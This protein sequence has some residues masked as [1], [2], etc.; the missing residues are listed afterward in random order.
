MKTRHLH[1]GWVVIFL[2][3][4]QGC[5]GLNPFAKKGPS[6]ELKALQGLA[7]GIDQSSKSTKAAIEALKHNSM[8]VPGVLNNTPKDG[9]GVMTASRIAARE[10]N[11]S[12]SVIKDKDGNPILDKNGLPI[13]IYDEFEQLVMTGYKTELAGEGAGASSIEY[14]VGGRSVDNDR[15]ALTG[16]ATWDGM[17][18]YVKDLKGSIT[19]NS[20][21]LAAEIKAE[22][23]GRAKILEALPGVIRETF[24]GTNKR[25]ELL[26]DGRVRLITALGDSVIGRLISLTPTGAATEG[27][28]AVKAIIDSGNG[29][30]EFVISETDQ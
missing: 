2:I 3:V 27:A 30:E 24:I 12:L 26:Y 10:P 21:A 18:L 11:G 5:S 15:K 1:W 23:E 14:V 20:D 9:T 6:E 4:T 29:P 17:R 8:I 19:K 7:Y 16:A 22:T 25:I 28:R 13:V